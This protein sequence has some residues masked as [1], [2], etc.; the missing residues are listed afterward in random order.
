MELPFKITYRKINGA[1]YQFDSKDHIGILKY[2]LQDAPDFQKQIEQIRKPD[3][4]NLI[5]LTEEYQKKVC[6]DENCIV[7]ERRIPFLKIA[8]NPVIGVLLITGSNKKITEVGG[9]VY[10]WMPRSNENLYFKTGLVY[11]SKT[12]A[13]I[14]TGE[15]IENDYYSTYEIPLQIQYQFSS[16]RFKPLAGIGVNYLVLKHQL[17]DPNP[18]GYKKYTDVGHTL[19]LTAGFNYKITNT[20]ALSASL[21]SDFTPLLFLINDRQ[22]KFRLLSSSLRFGLYIKI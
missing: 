1:N 3:R 8:L 18:H 4:E 12:N 20:L 9:L 22:E 17:S 2:Y 14:S 16:K 21:N 5:K 15:T 6:K 7:Y 13:D 19:C 10:F 11:K